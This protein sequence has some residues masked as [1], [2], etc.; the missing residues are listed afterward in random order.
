MQEARQTYLTPEEYLALERQSETKSEYF[1]GEIYAMSGA[2]EAHNLI[3]ANLVSLLII[4]LRGRPCKTYPSDMRVQV[5]ATGLYTYPDA[6]VVCGRAEFS[7]QQKNTLRNPTVVFEVL[8]S[9]TESYDR[10]AKFAHYRTL[11]SLTDYVLVL[12]TEA[13]IE[14]FARQA[15]DKW[16]LSVYQGL[17]AVALLPSIDCEL[18]LTDLYDKVELPPAETVT[19]RIVREHQSEYEYEDDAY[20]H[21]SYPNVNR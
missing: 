13:R 5:R 20:A 19:L 6:S 16:L 1:N 11:E 3:F 8:S 4:A 21:P 2:S 17:G 12:Q 18:P 7:D 15:T 10:G 14:H 9:T